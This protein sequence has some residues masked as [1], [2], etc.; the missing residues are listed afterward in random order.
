MNLFN[1]LVWLFTYVLVF[2][3]NSP[4]E[5]DNFIPKKS[6]DTRIIF[7]KEVLVPILV[8][9]D[10][11]NRSTI[12]G[13]QYAYD[14]SRNWHTFTANPGFLINRVTKRDTVLWESEDYGNEHG[15]KVF[16]GFNGFNERVFRVYFLH[17]E[18]P[19][20]KPPER[21]IILPK[22]KDSQGNDVNLVGV[23]V[24]IKRSTKLVTYKRDH[25]TGA[26]VFTVK[27]PYRIG[28]LMN[29]NNQLWRYKRGPYPDKVRITVNANCSPYCRFG[30]PKPATE[31]DPELV[32]LDVQNRKST[33]QVQYEFNT[34]R[35]TH[36][37]IP[38]PGFL[39]YE[40]RMKG[41]LLWSC[42]N[43]FYPTKV[44]VSLN[45]HGKPDLKLSFPEVPPK[46]PLD[47]RGVEIITKGSKRPNNKSKYT[48]TQPSSG[49]F[50]YEF[51]P[52]AQC[53]MLRCNGR[54]LWIYGHFNCRHYPTTI[55][56][57]NESV[58][59]IHFTCGFI[60]YLRLPNGNWSKGIPHNIRVPNSS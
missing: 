9:V 41:K 29:G 23:N 59:D 16:V 37:F 28:L 32:L 51:K 17:P 56:Y 21:D 35:Q 24:K 34:L 60:K 36:T 47:Q 48:L 26:D 31:P 3:R 8:T 12:E 2:Y 54:I 42:E 5:C 50:K 49:R 25:V 20:L 6:R 33:D 55:F 44:L 53:T 57:T 40:I 45:K 39:I 13:L 7:F 43:A 27:E 14:Q 46:K 38:N 22:S 4:V 19:K 18:P 1:W 30:Y 10:I 58:M 52:N 11:A 15:V